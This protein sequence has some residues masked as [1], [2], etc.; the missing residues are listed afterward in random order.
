MSLLAW[1]VLSLFRLK[2]QKKSNEENQQTPIK[3]EKVR[4]TYQST[5]HQVTISVKPCHEHDLLNEAEKQAQSDA[6]NCDDRSN[7]EKHFYAAPL[8]LHNAERGRA[9]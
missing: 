2:T 5:Q 6:K 1:M 8:F 3:Q 7:L 4:Y 9:F